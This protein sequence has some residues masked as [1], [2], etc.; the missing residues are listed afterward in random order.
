MLWEQGVEGSNPFAPTNKKKER[1][2]IPFSFLPINAH[3]SVKSTIGA[4]GAFF[5]TE[6]MPFFIVAWLAYIWLEPMTWPLAAIKLK[7]GLPLDASLTAKRFSSKQFFLT[8][9]TPLRQEALVL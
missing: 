3:S 7:Y 6:A 2:A 5:L 9:S 4:S 8:D 1:H